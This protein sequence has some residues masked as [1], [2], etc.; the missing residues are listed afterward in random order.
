[1]DGGKFFAWFVA[2]IAVA[3]LLEYVGH[4][5]A[6]AAGAFAGVAVLVLA[7]VAALPERSRQPRKPSRLRKAWRQYMGPLPP[8]E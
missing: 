5:P 3:V 8:Q 7:L 1:M 6:A 2:I 4:V